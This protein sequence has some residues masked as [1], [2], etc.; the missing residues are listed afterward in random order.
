[1]SYAILLLFI[2]YN[3][4]HGVWL[5]FVHLHRICLYLFFADQFL[6]FEK[7]TGIFHFELSLC[8]FDSCQIALSFSYLSEFLSSTL[9]IKNFQQMKKNNMH[10]FEYY[11]YNQ[12]T[13]TILS[14]KLYSS[15]LNKMSLAQLLRWNDLDLILKYTVSA[16][17]FHKLLMHKNHLVNIGKRRLNNIQ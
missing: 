11:L 6:L 2:S 13:T 1:M 7:M 5:H 14:W 9:W 16:L 12:I 4:F 15:S 3:L 17:T 8:E 10:N